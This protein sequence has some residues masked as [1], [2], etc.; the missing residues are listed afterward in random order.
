M[1]GSSTLVI[2]LAAVAVILGT[3][4]VCSGAAAKQPSKVGTLN[5][6]VVATGSGANVL[7]PESANVYILFASP[8]EQRGTFSHGNDVGTAG[9]QF[10]FKLNNLIEKNEDLKRLQKKA[11]HNPQPEDANQIADYCLQSVDEALTWVR[12]WLTN[13]PDLSWQMKTIA[14]D[15]QGFW[16]AEGLQPGEYV[17]VVRG[18]FPGYDADWEG[19]VDLAPGKTISLPLTRPRFI[20]RK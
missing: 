17:V 19:T 15:A 8:M 7:P 14:S 1:K 9:G 13:H 3:S 6:Q 5:G 10:R 4:N 20:R 2:A 16:S 18:T 11:H 12:S